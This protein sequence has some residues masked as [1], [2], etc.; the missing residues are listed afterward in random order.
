MR[1]FNQA[2][3][4]V[5]QLALFT[6]IPFVWYIICNKKCSGFLKW[7]GLKIPYADRTLLKFTAFT[8]AA[9]TVISIGILYSL[10]GIDTAAGMFSGMGTAGLPYA[11]IYAFITTAL[12]EEILFRG[13]LLKRLSG[14][15]GFPI[16]NIVQSILF[17]LLHG[18][19][20][21]SL[22]SS[23]KIILIIAFTGF[24][25]WCMGYVNEKKADGSIIPGWIIHGIANLFSAAVSMF[26]IIT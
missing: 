26:C 24:I 2:L 9:F 10:K 12:S 1:L 6:V 22:I 7:I 4:A 11:V 3:S 20:F 25:A 23:V 14:K 16:G 19:M 17:G 5:V 21:C 15:F 13:F 18:A 8:I